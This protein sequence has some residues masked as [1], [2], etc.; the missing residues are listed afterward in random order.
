MDRQQP[1]RARALLLGDRLELRGAGGLLVGDEAEEALEVAAA[2]LLVRAREPHQLAQVRVAALA[3]R[4]CEHG[5]VVV[6]LG[7]DLLA[8][9]LEGD[10]HRRGGEPLVA[11]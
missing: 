5:E 6:V 10:T 11:L 8:E 7:D 3:V 1:H 4:P 9:P 2:Q